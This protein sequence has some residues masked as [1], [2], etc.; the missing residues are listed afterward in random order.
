MNRSAYK[1]Q[2]ADGI[3]RETQSDFI[4]TIIATM[5]PHRNRENKCVNQLSKS[6]VA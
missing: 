2:V 6:L 4:H 3:S 5:L 1:R